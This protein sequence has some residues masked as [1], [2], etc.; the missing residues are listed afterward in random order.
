MFL[1]FHTP[2]LKHLASKLPVLVSLMDNKSFPRAHAP[3]FTVSKVLML[4]LPPIL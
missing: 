4:S 1:S 3:Y 2:L